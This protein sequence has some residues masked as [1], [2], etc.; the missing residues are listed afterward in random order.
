MTKQSRSAA[1]LTEW[2]N[3]KQTNYF[4]CTKEISVC[5]QILL[6]IWLIL[7]K[8]AVIQYASSNQDIK[9]KPLLQPTWQELVQCNFQQEQNCQDHYRK[10]EMGKCTPSDLCSTF[11][12]NV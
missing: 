1:E 10:Y 4:G 6:Q 12:C 2:K 11:C 8:I 3:L 5:S 9:I 7:K